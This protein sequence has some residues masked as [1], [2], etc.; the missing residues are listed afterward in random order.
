MAHQLWILHAVAVIGEQADTTGSQLP[1]WSQRLAFA[2]YR[3]ASRGMYVAEGGA[4]RLGANELDHR[5]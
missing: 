3:D 5:Q 1:E 4:A 2:I